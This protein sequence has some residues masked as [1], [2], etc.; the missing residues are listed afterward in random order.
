MITNNTVIGG[1]ATIAL[2][3][4]EPNSFADNSLLGNSKTH[5][6]I[7]G[8]KLTAEEGGALIDLRGGAGTVDTVLVSS[9]VLSNTVGAVNSV[10][11][12]SHTTNVTTVPPSSSAG[13]TITSP[14]LDDPSATTGVSSG[15]RSTNGID[16][17]SIALDPQP[18][19][20]YLP[21]PR[22]TGDARFLTDGANGS[23]IALLGNYMASSFAMAG[24]NHGGTIVSREDVESHHP[25][26]AGSQ[27]G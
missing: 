2:Q 27:H 3:S 20:G 19:L 21:I 26:L 23:N 15:I 13:P 25:L 7:S 17:P 9:N 18:T 14:P 1:A 24:Y 4:S 12:D 6:T 10:L 11:Q 22:S 5:V 16:L 8:N